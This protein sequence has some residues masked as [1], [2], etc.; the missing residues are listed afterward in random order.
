[1]KATDII[2][3]IMENRRWSRQRLAEEI[4]CKRASN[5][6]TYLDRGANIRID[7]LV[8]MAEAMGCEVIVR[9]KMGD[10]KEWKVTI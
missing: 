2:R 8:K 7:N 4:G 5:I 10:R 9:D 3:E 6:G 1:M